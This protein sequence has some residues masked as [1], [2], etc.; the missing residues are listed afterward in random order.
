MLLKC[1]K[2]QT[3]NVFTFIFLRSIDQ[4]EIWYSIQ[5]KASLFASFNQL[6]NIAKMRRVETE[7]L[8]SRG[9]RIAQRTKFL[10]GIQTEQ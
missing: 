2:H 1:I 9:L 8:Q 3:R 10:K 4:V 7:V 6:R 5:R